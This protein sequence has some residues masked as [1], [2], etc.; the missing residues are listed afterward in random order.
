M[1]NYRG[2]MFVKQDR[3]EEDIVFVYEDDTVITNHLEQGSVRSRRFT[4]SDTEEFE[5]FLK[6]MHFYQKEGERAP[7]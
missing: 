2:K 4:V 1:T 5:W 7:W 6:E 3:E